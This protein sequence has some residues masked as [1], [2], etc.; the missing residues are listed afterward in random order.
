M[1]MAAEGVAV[2]RPCDPTACVTW[3]SSATGQV[4]WEGIYNW[5]LEVAM[6]G[7]PPRKRGHRQDS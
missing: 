5:S 7:K 3:Y 6:E 1:G 4:A 2:L